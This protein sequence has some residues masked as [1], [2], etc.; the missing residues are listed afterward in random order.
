M[1]LSPTDDFCQRR[2]L[3]KNASFLNDISKKKVYEVLPH[4]PQISFS[5]N[6]GWGGTPTEFSLNFGL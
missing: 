3:L 2:L 4:N 6:G 5:K 1:N